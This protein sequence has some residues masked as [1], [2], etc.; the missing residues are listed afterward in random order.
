MSRGKRVLPKE[1]YARDPK[2]VAIDLLGKILVRILDGTRLSGMIVET[3]AYYGENDPA[4]R[5]RGGMRAYNKPM[6]GEPGRTFIYMV[7]GNWLLNVV[8]HEPGLVGAVLIR[9]LEPIEGIDIMMSNC[10]KSCIKGLTSGPGRLTKALRIDCSLNYVDLTNGDGPL[11]I[12]DNRRVDP[13]EIGRSHRIG[14]RIDLEEELRFF[15]KGN[16]YVSRVKT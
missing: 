5:A 3:E 16:E 6:W 11:F 14:V 10:G 1:F 9:A 13:E 7:H 2:L 4:S 15:I 8:A 12:V